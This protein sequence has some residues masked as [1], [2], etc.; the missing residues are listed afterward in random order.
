MFHTLKYKG[1]Y[2]HL[3]AVG[4]FETATVQIFNGHDFFTKECKSF[5]SAQIF[6]AKWIKKENMK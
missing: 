2:I 6:I 3:S 1:H 5:R 4:N